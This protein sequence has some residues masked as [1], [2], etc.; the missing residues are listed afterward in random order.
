MRSS[1][2]GPPSRRRSTDA[3][4]HQRGRDRRGRDQ[5][6]TALGRLAPPGTRLPWRRARPGSRSRR[7]RR[8]GRAGRPGVRAAGPGPPPRPAR[9]PRAPRRAGGRPRRAAPRRRHRP[10]LRLPRPTRPRHREPQGTVPAATAG[11]PAPG[12]RPPAGRPGRRRSRGRAPRRG[13]TAPAAAGRVG[14][15]HPPA[16][17]G[18]TSM[19]EPSVSGADRSVRTPST[20]KLATE[21][22]RAS[23][24]PCRQDGSVEHLGERR[25]G[26]RLLAD[27]RSGPCRRPVADRPAGHDRRRLPRVTGAFPRR[28]RSRRPDS[29]A[30]ITDHH[31]SWRQGQEGEPREPAVAPDERAAA[32]DRG[33]ARSRPALAQPAGR[34]GGGV[35]AARGT[36]LGRSAGGRRVATCRTSA[37]CAASSAPPAS[38]AP[39]C[40]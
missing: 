36:P 15:A 9:A 37:R 1:Q 5:R 31:V 10:P 30:R 38:T 2:P 29:A 32:F 3:P 21:S 33:A 20:R 27:A 14:H 6:R 13:P 17:G 34:S 4:R 25:A 26:V 19:V 35:G 16:N 22:T 12:A 28:E 23:S 40:W 8:S 24:A 18:R 7:G 39:C 11:R